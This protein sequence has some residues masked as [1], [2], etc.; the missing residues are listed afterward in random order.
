M[1]AGNASPRRA[2]PLG[3]PTPGAA[4]PPARAPGGCGLP[5][6]F[7]RLLQ[8]LHGPVEGPS[9]SFSLTDG[10]GLILQLGLGPSF[11]IPGAFPWR[12]Y[13]AQYLYKGGTL[14]HVTF[15]GGLGGKGTLKESTEFAFRPALPALRSLH[16]L[17]DPWLSDSPLA[18]SPPRSAAPPPLPPPQPRVCGGGGATRSTPLS[19]ARS[20]PPGVEVSE[21]ALP[22]PSPRS[23]S[24]PPPGGRSTGR[25]AGPLPPGLSRTA[26]QR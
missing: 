24:P 20:A 17:R 9:I 22:H 25:E 3:V 8:P 7:P 23:R 19:P 2:P 26:S 16:K 1:E 11:R 15:P 14:F 4:R 21:A 12:H 5:A 6:P 10:L 18:T 13:I